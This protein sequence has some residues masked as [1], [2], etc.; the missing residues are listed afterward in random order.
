[1]KMK[2]RSFNITH[3]DTWAD[4]CSLTFEEI[5]SDD[6]S[7]SNSSSDSYDMDKIM[8]SYSVEFPVNKSYRI[9]QLIL[10]IGYNYINLIKKFKILDD[11][12]LF[13]KQQYYLY[14]GNYPFIDDKRSKIKIPDKTKCLLTE[15]NSS[16]DSYLVIISENHIENHS[17]NCFAK[18]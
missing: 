2:I 15:Y 14:T 5:N 12:V 17:L 6:D 9:Y 18:W 1:M 16:E 11:A 7:D 4:G 8:N 13:S 3:H 10:G